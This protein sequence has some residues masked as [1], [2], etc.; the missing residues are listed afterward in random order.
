MNLMNEPNP[1]EVRMPSAAPTP[2]M[3]NKILKYLVLV[4]LVLLVISV[5]SF[6]WGGGSSFRERDVVVEIEGPSQASVGDE[7][8]YKLSYENNTRLT[9]HGLNFL[10]TYPQG[11]VIVKDGVVSSDETITFTVDELEAGKKEEREFKV[12]L[13]GDRG[14]IKTAKANMSFKA[15][16]LKSA[17]EKTSTAS[18]TITSVPVPLTLVAPPNAT[19]GQTINY[20]LDYRNDSTND[21]NDLKIEFTY[22]DGFA[23]QSFEPSPNGAN[24]I[25]DVAS[26]KRGAGSRIAIQ[27]ILSGAENETKN[28]QV[29]VKRKIGENYIDFER[30]SSSTIIANPIVSLVI[31][32][33]NSANYSANLGEELTYKI[34]YRNRSGFN[35]LGGRVSVRLEGDMYDF[36]KMQTQG[37]LY[38]SSTQTIFWNASN[39]NRLEDLGPNEQGEFIFKVTLKNQF[40]SPLTGTARDRFVKAT[41][42]FNAQSVQ[43][44]T[45]GQDISTTSSTITKISTQPTFNQFMYHRDPTVGESGPFPPKAGQETTFVV[46]WQIANPGN[47]IN[48]AEATAVL[49]SN[50]SWDSLVGVSGTTVQPTFNATTSTI[51][52]KL[53]KVPFGVGSFAPRYEAVF[54]VKVRPVDNDIGKALTIIRNTK[55]VGVDGFTNQSV[56]VSSPN[57]DTS[58]VVDKPGEGKVQ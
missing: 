8:V 30:A 6:L 52:W 55:L 20:I 58:K 43:G 34:Q 57:L 33:N 29:A 25:W 19:A 15:G 7:V 54:K 1:G 10:F 3:A 31:S 50:V 39:E 18:T 22:P 23:P 16:N 17:F 35:L 47:D 4:A 13:V 37:G 12:F 49:P 21:I 28:I 27:G 48:K 14:D 26:L 51:T 53:E 40:T 45:G 56:T 46:Y 36:S 41:A 24:N 5:A 2:T 42:V 11:S 9:L 38:D 44:N 32:A